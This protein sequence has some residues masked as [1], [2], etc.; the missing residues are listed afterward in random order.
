[1][2][3]HLL[4]A[5]LLLFRHAH[6]FLSQPPLKGLVRGSLPS[7]ALSFLLLCSLQLLTLAGSLQ[8]PRSLH[9]PR[10]NTTVVIVM[11]GW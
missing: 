9:L 4:L 6:P 2:A 7:T 10:V 5:E 3:P 11:V 1:L 8:L